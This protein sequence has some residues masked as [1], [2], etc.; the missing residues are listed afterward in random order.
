M[1]HLIPAENACATQLDFDTTDRRGFK[2]LSLPWM[3]ENPLSGLGAHIMATCDF[4]EGGQILFRLGP[5]YQR[6]FIPKNVLLT[7]RPKRIRSLQYP[8]STELKFQICSGDRERG[9]LNF[10]ISS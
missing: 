9:Q 7:L 2:A 6:G 10:T 5:W 4:F 8:G 3:L 1:E